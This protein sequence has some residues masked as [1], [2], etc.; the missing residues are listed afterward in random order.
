M[1][2]KKVKR[3]N[4]IRFGIRNKISGTTEC[5]R[6]AIFR[7]NKDI[8]VQLIDDEN[9][10]T[11]SNVS[12]RQKDIAASKGTKTEK[13]KMVG[14]EMAKTALKLGIK[15]VVFDR[16]GFLYHGRVKALADGAREGGL[17]F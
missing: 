15:N 7:S 6:M 4:R 8:Y 11:L 5:P 1:L 3:R 16:G 17:T 2:A 9:G 12:S 13:S 10:H 14:Q